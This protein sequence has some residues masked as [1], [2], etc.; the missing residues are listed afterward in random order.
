MSAVIFDFDGT[1]ADSFPIFIR[2]VENI[3][4]RGPFSD[5]EI[6]ELRQH[7]VGEVLEMLKIG[8][9]RLPWLLAR[10]MKEIDRHQGEI[11]IFPDISETIDDLLRDGHNLHIVSS[12]S[13]HGIQLFLT[14][15][16]L[17]N[18]FESVSGNIGL[19]GKPKTLKKLQKQYGYHPTECAFV[20][21]E[22]RDIEAAN[23]AGIKSVA[24]AWGFNSPATLEQQNP[25]D[26]IFQPRALAPSIKNIFS[27]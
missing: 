20:G 27:E 11:T 13:S 19:F 1:L 21:D 16:R 18:S 22:V 17:A 15:Y 10:G 8:K 5:E 9:W 7:S 25:S 3:L 24:V 6:E 4:N 14:R 26:L 2:V 23:R 12:H